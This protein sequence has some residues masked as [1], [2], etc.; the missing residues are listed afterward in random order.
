MSPGTDLHP[1]RELMKDGIR[2]RFDDS[3]IAYDRYESRTG[4]FGALTERLVAEMQSRETRQPTMVLDA[5]AGT[6]VSSRI[7]E[8][9]GERL[10]SLDLSREML[11]HNEGHHRVQADFD[12]LPFDRETFDAVAFTASLFLTPDP[13]RAVREARRVCRPGGTVGAVAPLGWTTP[14][15]EDVFAALERDSRSP[16]GAAEIETALRS[17]FSVETGRISFD[18]TGDALRE[19]H[20]IPAMSARLYPRLDH[21]TRIERVRVLLADVDGPLEQHWRWMVGVEDR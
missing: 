7:L 2:S 14:D 11:H 1:G 16:T 18:T 21:A 19:F 17:A 13:E 20:T 9:Y 5:G 6:G 8:G 4:R 15:G 3:P 12:R 10:V